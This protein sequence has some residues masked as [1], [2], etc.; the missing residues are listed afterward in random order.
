MGPGAAPA[1]EE[2]GGGGPVAAV[3]ARIPAD[4]AA[5]GARMSVQGAGDLGLGVAC[6]AQ[7]GELVAL[8]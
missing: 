7:G 6:L 5:D 4:L 8:T 3:V 1:G 2:I